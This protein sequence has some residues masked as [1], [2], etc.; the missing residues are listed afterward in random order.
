MF[1]DS[2]VEAVQKTARELGAEYEGT[3]RNAHTHMHARTHTHTQHISNKLVKLFDAEIHMAGGEIA[4]CEVQMSHWY[5][6]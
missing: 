2:V 4:H 6:F 1:D 3:G 5:A